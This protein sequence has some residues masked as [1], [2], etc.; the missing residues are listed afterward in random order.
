M[1]DRKGNGL[2]RLY[3]RQEMYR[4]PGTSCHSACT[5]VKRCI[6]YPVPPVIQPPTHVKRV[7]ALPVGHVD[8]PTHSRNEYCSS[9]Y[10]SA[11]C[12]TCVTSCGTPGTA[13]QSA[14]ARPSRFCTRHEG[15]Q[16]FGG[17]CPPLRH[18]LLFHRVFLL[19]IE[20]HLSPAAS[21]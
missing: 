6:E 13:C 18:Y 20:L 19:L 2:V 16:L 5:H 12:R 21:P 3:T 1:G 4:V 17:R 10:L 7:V 15:K 8:P 11:R 14:H 9:T